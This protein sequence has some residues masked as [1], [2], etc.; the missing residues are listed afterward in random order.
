MKS[1]LTKIKNNLQNNPNVSAAWLFGSVAS[2][3]HK[4]DSDIDIAVLFT[5]GL[6]KY[7]RF[8]LRLALAAELTRLVGR[9]VDLIDMQA[10][11]LYLQHQARKTG[12]LMLEKDHYYRLI[13][14]V[15]SRREYFDI[16]PALKLRNQKLIQKAL[17]GE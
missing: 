13:F 7:E 16:A 12:K 1:S 15:K 11:P 3:K 17:G 9:D 2:G 5:S 4:K 14:D 10:V 8:E 6:L